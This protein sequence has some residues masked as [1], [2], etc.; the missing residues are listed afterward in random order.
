REQLRDW[1]EHRKPAA[2]ATHRELQAVDADALS[3]ADL[4]TYLK[5]CRDHHAAML[6]QH[7]RFTASA[8]LPTG[9]FL[10]H[11]GDWTGLPH[12]ELL[13]LLRGSS[14]V[15]SGGSHEMQRL[16][17]AFAVDP[18]ARA[19]LASDGDPA[20]A[21]ARLRA[22]GGEAGAA[23]SGYLDLVGHRII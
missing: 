9:D 22:L 16:K 19:A 13:G 18:A 11:V 3:D 5:R 7:M 20:E 14:E 15:S 10:A 17:A 12:A 21:L 4:I 2:I 8:I 23:L 6:A 1:D